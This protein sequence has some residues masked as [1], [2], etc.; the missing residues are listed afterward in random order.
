MGVRIIWVPFILWRAG[1]GVMFMVALCVYI[2]VL[3]G[4]SNHM[5]S[6][7]IVA[8]GIWSYVYG[9]TVCIPRGVGWAF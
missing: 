7:Y 6:V 1:S 8:S 9:A 3:G 4:R 2:G 5:G